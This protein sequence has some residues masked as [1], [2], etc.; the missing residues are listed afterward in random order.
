MTYDDLHVKKTDEETPLLAAARQ[1][2]EALT[3]YEQAARDVLK[4]RLDS[5]RDVEHAS[6]ALVQVAR[7]D[8]QLAARVSALV[9]AIS[10]VRDR[11]QADAEAVQR[12]AAEVL[13]RKKALDALL[14]RLGLLGD[15][16]KAVGALFDAVRKDPSQGLDDAIARTGELADLAQAFALEAQ[17]QGFADLVA[18]GHALRQQLLSVKSK[19]GLV[20]ERTPRA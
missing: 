6:E 2:A 8:E 9:G 18:E 3:G 17:T 14:A 1:L 20:K 16:V 5:R 11:Q 7:I 15:A 19:L 12:R 13:E 4:A 10:G